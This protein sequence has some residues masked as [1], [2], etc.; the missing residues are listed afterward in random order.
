MRLLS[1]LWHLI[2]LCKIYLAN[3]QPLLRICSHSTNPLVSLLQHPLKKMAEQVLEPTEGFFISDEQKAR[4]KKNR[5]HYDFI[6]KMIAKAN[7]SINEMVAKYDG[8]ITLRCTVPSVDRGSTITIISDIGTN[9]NQFG[10][11]KRLC[12]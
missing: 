12:H 11:F 3:P 7:I 9:M 6:E 5:E 1:E 8:E 10:S 2:L 4:I